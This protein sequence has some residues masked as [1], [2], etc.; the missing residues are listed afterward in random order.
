M[1]TGQFFLRNDRLEH[2]QPIRLMVDYDINS[3]PP[4]I[5]EPMISGKPLSEYIEFIF[6]RCCGLASLKWRVFPVN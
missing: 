6:D 3:D 5:V 4:R 1:D 2:G